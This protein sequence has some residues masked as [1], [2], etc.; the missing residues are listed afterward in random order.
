MAG[1]LVFKGVLLNDQGSCTLGV[2]IAD[3]GISYQMPAISVTVDRI[4]PVVVLFSSPVANELTYLQDLDPNTPGIQLILVVRVRGVEKDQPVTVTLTQPDATT[5]TANATV[6]SDVSNNGFLD[7]SFGP[8]QTT[9]K[10]GV[11]KL[12]ATTTDKAGNV[13]DPFTL[14]VTANSGLPSVALTNPVQ[15]SPSQVFKW[16]ATSLREVT[17][18]L[19][20]FPSNTDIRI[21]SN[22]SNLSGPPCATGGY[23]V[24]AT[25]T[26]L[27]ELAAV[28]L[29]SLPDGVHELIAEAF[30]PAAQQWVASLANKTV[31]FQKRTVDIRTVLPVISNFTSPSNA[32]GDEYLNKAEVEVGPNSFRFTVDGDQSGKMQIL[33]NGTKIVDEDFTGPGTFSKVIALPESPTKNHKLTARLVDSYGNVSLPLDYLIKVDVT[34]PNFAFFAPATS[35]VKKGDSVDVVVRSVSQ[36]DSVIGQTVTL[37]DGGVPFVTTAIVNTLGQATFSGVLT[38]KANNA[39]Y[40]LSI[41][42]TDKAGNKKTINHTIDVVVDVREP[43]ITSFGHKG[44]TGSQKLPPDEYLDGDDVNI[45]KAGFQ[46]TALISATTNDALPDDG[47]KTFNLYVDY[48]CTTE[49]SCTRTR[50][51]VTNGAFTG[52][53][54]E[55]EFDVPVSSLK[56]YVLRVEVLDAV[57]NK[58]TQTSPFR[59]NSTICEVALSNVPSYYNRANVTDLVDGPPAT[60][61]AKLDVLISAGCPASI[62]KVEILNNDA[63]LSPALV[64]TTSPFDSFMLPIVDGT[65]YNLKVRA[66]FDDGGTPKVVDS[67][68]ES[69]IADLTAPTLALL[70]HSYTVQNGVVVKGL[71]QTDTP[72]CTLDPGSDGTKPDTDNVNCYL[73]RHNKNASPTAGLGVEFLAEVK[74]AN[75]QGGRI[76]VTDPALSKSITT[77]GTTQQ[78]IV[79]RDEAL[80]LPKSENKTLTITL[81][82]A[83]GNSTSITLVVSADPLVPNAPANFQIDDAATKRRVPAVTLNWTSASDDGAGVGP[84]SAIDLRYSKNE[85]TTESDFL[86]ACKVGDIPNHPALPTPQAP[87]NSETYTVTGPDARKTECTFRPGMPNEGGQFFFAM[88]VRD[89][90]GNWSTIVTDDVVLTWRYTTV[91]IK[92]APTNQDWGAYIHPIGDINGDG[93]MDLVVGGKTTAG[94]CVVYGRDVTTDAQVV[95]VDLATPVNPTAGYKCLLNVAATD[96]SGQPLAL[97]YVAEIVFGTGDI[98]GDGV[99]DFVVAAEKSVLVYLGKKNDQFDSQPALV[100][101]GMLGTRPGSLSVDGGNVIAF[102]DETKPLNDIVIAS[103]SDDFVFVISGRES[104][105]SATTLKLDLSVRSDAALRAARVVAHRLVISKANPI[106]STDWVFG[107]FIALAPSFDGASLQSIVVSGEFNGTATTPMP[108]PRVFLLPGSA[109]LDPATYAPTVSYSEVLPTDDADKLSGDLVATRLVFNLARSATQPG[110]GNAAPLNRD[111]I[112]AYAGTSYDFDGNGTPDLLLHNTTANICFGEP[113]NL[114]GFKGSPGSYTLV[115]NIGHFVLYGE[116]LK[117]KQGTEI[118]LTQT[119]VETQLNADGSWKHDIVL[120]KS[121]ATLIGTGIANPL[122]ENPAV[123]DYAPLGITGLRQDLAFGHFVVGLAADYV[124]IRSNLDSGGYGI[125]TFPNMDY[126]MVTD[127]LNPTSTKFSL[128]YVRSL[129]D[130]NGDQFPDLVVASDDMTMIDGSTVQ[131][132]IILW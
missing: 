74:D 81:F 4:A 128:F 93:K 62:T 131:Y 30:F 25:T 54:V 70:S 91:A 36:D 56:L 120:L 105:S 125:G 83:A 103:S 31:N 79:G 124:F 99:D 51:V 34:D 106:A 58:A 24:V 46:L 15:T 9:L 42:V 76:E 39:P 18:A 71:S 92:N 75:L 21:C 113:L 43:K 27:N 52:T 96:L 13:S 28:S 108:A 102:S 98:N 82:D 17:V 114:C 65:T 6:P 110:L 64:A 48:E 55:Q 3:F 37:S 100:A 38:N 8:T 87:N 80:N 84:V 67:L 20:N 12:V 49:T 16:G 44:S 86:A 60:A 41:E 127:P 19:A 117:G 40:K 89:K 33:L 77:G 126:D 69:V 10:D 63:P 115:P 23:T 95:E 118:V 90:L 11:V 2:T 61:K 47:P 66:T 45:G 129:G 130:F 111:L 14:Y 94:F 85:I 107:K 72:V 123:L 78:I 109:A 112:R 1:K 5:E 121:G 73:A 32:N 122:L 53:D 101:Y 29:A 132:A 104:L 7:V 97:Q 57:G 88:R 22:N 119:N 50:T 35:P 116:F 26:S 59:V 68:P